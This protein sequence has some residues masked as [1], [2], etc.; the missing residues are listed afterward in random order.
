[1]KFIFR[2]ANHEKVTPSMEVDVI[3]GKYYCFSCGS[4]GNISESKSVTKLV[5]AHLKGVIE[6]MEGYL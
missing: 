6:Y 3:K 4:K 2:C 5:I 1:M